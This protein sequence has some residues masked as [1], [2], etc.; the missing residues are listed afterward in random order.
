MRKD[1]KK[2]DV[3]ISYASEDRQDVAIPLANYL[4]ELGV[5]VWF[6][7]FELKVGDSLRGKIDE[8]LSKSKYGVV[9]LSPSFFKKH[10]TNIELRGLAQKE[11]DGEKV[12][13]PIWYK[14]NECDIREFSPPLA[15]RIATKWQEE[16]MI[17]V[18]SKILK[19]VRPNIIEKIHKDLPRIRSG[20]ELASLVRGVHISNFHN[21]EPKNEEELELVSDFLQ[22]IKD[23]GDILHELEPGQQV[24]TEYYLNERIK[25][26]ESAGWSLYGLRE[27]KKMKIADI[28]DNWTL[29]TIAVLRGEPEQVI[30]FGK[31]I[32]VYRPE[33]DLL[34]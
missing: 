32:L 3:F 26:L 27:T 12:I 2:W 5:S 18:A 14:V 6:D 29:A 15:D 28:V 4:K 19:V 30:E 31:G 21:D 23:Y 1:K 24:K 11:V 33:K 7:Q 17:G 13:L 20:S 16:G 9:I 34:Q 8:G 22:E 10:Y 25:E